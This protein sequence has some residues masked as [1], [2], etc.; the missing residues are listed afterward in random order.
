MF[1]FILC[2]SWAVF[3]S[4]LMS[5][6][7]QSFRV[8][9]RGLRLHTDRCLPAR[10]MSI[11]PAPSPHSPPNSLCSDT[12]PAALSPCSSSSSHCSHSHCLHFT[13][14]LSTTPRGTHFH[15]GPVAK[16]LLIFPDACILFSP[17]PLLCLHAAVLHEIAVTQECHA[18]EAQPTPALP[19][20]T[21]PSPA[22]RSPT[23]QAI[24]S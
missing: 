15:L 13:V 18:C 8:G 19:N 7:S 21:P 23:D 5:Q 6:P 20:M 10:S 9:K 12:A 17:S 16:G 1:R 4:F 2:W 3:F 14:S 22:W 24:L 11:P